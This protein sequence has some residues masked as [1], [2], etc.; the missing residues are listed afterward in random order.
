MCNSLVTAGLLL[1]GVIGKHAALSEAPCACLWCA[2]VLA[3]TGENRAVAQYNK[4]LD[5][6]FQAGVQASLATGLGIGAT[7]LVMFSSYALALWYGSTLILQ[8]AGYTGGTVMTVL[9][10]V[11]IGGM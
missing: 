10:G 11:I 2:Q 7:M 5:K 4:R 8:N 9:F 6:A 3:F 1:L